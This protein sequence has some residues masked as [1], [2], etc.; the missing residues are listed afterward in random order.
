MP[1][2]MFLRVKLDRASTTKKFVAADGGRIK[3]LGEKTKPFKS[4]EGVHR[5]IKFR[6]A[7]V[8]K[9]LISMRKV[10][11]AFTVVVLDE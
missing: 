11:Q 9:P 6:S 8:V 3:E 2:E 5:F 4:V 10:V 1:E 7:S